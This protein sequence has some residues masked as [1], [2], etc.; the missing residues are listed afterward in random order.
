MLKL[1]VRLNSLPLV[2][3]IA[4]IVLTIFSYGVVVGRYRVFP[5]WI[6][7]DGIKVGKVL[8]DVILEDDRIVNMKY[9]GVYLKFSDMPLANP[10]LD[11]IEFVA[12]NELAAP[13]LWTGG[14]EQF[15]EYCPDSGCLAVEYNRR[16]EVTHAY[17]LRLDE[18]EKAQGTADDGE[19]P[20]EFSPNFS[21]V[22]DIRIF[23]VSRYSNGDLLVVFQYSEVAFP[24][25]A[26]V[27]RIDRDG[28]VV[29][30]RSDYSHHWAQI[31]DDDTALVPSMRIGS[32]PVSF[33]LK[34]KTIRI[35]DCN[36]P[37]RDSVHIIDE[38]GRLLKHIDLLDVL[39]ASPFASALQHALNSCAPL[40]LNF[41]HVLGD[42][43]GGAWG[44]EPGDL[45]VSL[46]NI[47]AFAILDRE[48]GR[49]KRLVR[50]SFL[51]QHSVQHLEGSLFLMFDNQ[52]Y[53]EVGGPSRLLAVDLVDGRQTTIFPNRST[54][55]SLR[56]LFFSDKL[57]HIDISADRRRV[58]IAFSEEGVGVEVRLADGEIMSIFRSLHDVSSLDQFPNERKTKAA[59]FKILGLEYI[60][61]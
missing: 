28:H 4:A 13:V 8:L 50:G 35:R 53:D 26:G 30:F 51:L 32:E 15:R 52:G 59:L 27:A 43:A 58:L 10:V 48:S 3:F 20:Y 31:L 61:E 47:S 17:P 57:G 22:R 37:Y 45:V 39:L 60:H 56:D 12:G 23:G 36:R 54:P 2:L 1:N 25:G 38:D 42:D 33:Q 41:I 11:R 21:F 14:H 16:G 29:W 34:G 9:T 55:E 24:Y 6:I 46:R 19:F 40:H 18:L 7:S 44:I 5:F 49:V